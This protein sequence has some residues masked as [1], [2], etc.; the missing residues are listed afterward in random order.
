MPKPAPAG[1]HQAAV[2][3]GERNL[4]IGRGQHL[5][6]DQREARHLIL[7]PR[8]RGSQHFRWHL[9]GGGL[10]I[11]GVE[12][13]QIARDALLD[14]RETAVHFRFRDVV[15]PRIDGLELAAV[16]RDTGFR[17]QTHLAALRN[18]LRADLL[19]RGATIL[20][21]FGY[22]PVIGDETSGQPHH[23]HVA[24]SLALQ[25]PAGMHAVEIAVDGELQEQRGMVRGPASHLSHDALEPQVA[26]TERIDEHIDCANRMALVDPVIQAFGQQR[27]L[28]A[29]RS[30][31]ETLHPIPHRFSKKIITWTGLS[32][33]LGHVWTALGCQ[34]ALVRC[35][36]G[37]SGH[38]FGL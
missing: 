17:Q 31:N 2:G 18:E 13:A 34:V 28:L 33:S 12:L 10:A 20:A 9:T 19:D 29:I 27:R 11:A 37:R 1:G 38:V 7:K 3:I 22:R 26:D 32:H 35:S 5:L 25:P 30:L 8:G 14:L 16:D 36:D 21:E 15:D 23:V 4:L 24:T 6:L